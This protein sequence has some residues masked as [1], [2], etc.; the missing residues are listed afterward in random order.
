MM[1][2]T[3]LEQIAKR[4]E[5]EAKVSS[6]EAVDRVRRMLFGVLP[7]DVRNSV[8]QQTQQRGI[9]AKELRLTEPRSEEIRVDSCL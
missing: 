5:W 1:R 3:A 6:P 7:E 2:Q 9:P 4:L 8:S